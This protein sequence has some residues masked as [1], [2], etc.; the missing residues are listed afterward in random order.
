MT[1]GATSKGQFIKDESG[2]WHYRMTGGAGFLDEALYDALDGIDGMRG[3]AVWFWFNGTLAP[4]V[5]GDTENSLGA[6]WLKWRTDYQADPAS[7]LE[8]LQKMI[9]EQK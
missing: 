3:R 6:R 9:L 1:V 5:R 8:N 4:I 2:L 7:L